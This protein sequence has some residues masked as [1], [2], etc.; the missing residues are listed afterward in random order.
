MR[1]NRLEIDAFQAIGH[2]DID[3]DNQGLVLI[4]G[5]NHDDDSA[6]SNGA[7]K[8]SIVSALQWCL[9]NITDRGDSGDAIV[10]RT[11]GKDTRVLTQIV[12][13]DRCYNVIR[14][15]KHRDH[16]NRVLLLDVTDRDNIIDL[17][18][19][20][21][22]ATQAHIN[23]IIGCSP[24]V[25]NSA[26]V[27]GQE[28]QV[29]LPNLS[30]KQLKLIVE[31]A[32]GIDKLQQA[33]VLARKAY[34][35]RKTEQEAALRQR[36]LTLATEAAITAELTGLEAKQ[37][38]HGD[39]HAEAVAAK[40][41]ELL[42]V[43]AGAKKQAEQLKSWDI[44]SLSEEQEAIATRLASID[45]E[46][47]Q[48][49][50][51]ESEQTRLGHELRHAEDRLKSDKALAATQKLQLDNVTSEIGTD[52][53]SCGQTITEAA[54]AGRQSA[55]AA[56][57]RDTVG[58]CKH[59]AAAI[60]ELRG[61]LSDAVSA[62]ET[63]TASMTDTSELVTRQQ[64]I[65]RELDA[66]AAC[67]AD[68]NMQTATAKRLRDELDKLE[69]STSP[70]LSLI[71][72]ANTRL[73][74][75]RTR[76][77][78]DN[79]A[80]EQAKAR[81]QT[82]GLVVEVFGP[83]GIRAYILDT[84]TPFLNDRTAR[85]LSVLSDNNISAVWSTLTKTAK[86]ELREKFAIEV[87]TRT[88]GE[89]FRSL[90]GGEKRKVRLSAALALQDLVSSRSAKPIQL[91]I[92]DEID[93]AVDVSGLERLMTV[94]EE[95]AKEKGTV[96]I[97]SHNSIGDWVRQHATVTKTDGVAT[98]TGALNLDLKDVTI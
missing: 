25:F 69:A 53:T 8:S 30:D 38:E 85:Y 31:E 18:Q 17:T 2:A 10:N 75:A 45:S 91:W 89:S 83:A 15:R 11:L 47:A 55:L 58:G 24:E 42:G 43:I 19:G 21:D 51:L 3:V 50:A 20:T 14:H 29:D 71:D 59:S 5:V 68:V 49:R 67:A 12:D 76:L 35:E 98:M 56:Q 82:A 61:K 36:E 33:Y 66:Q 13:G 40:R 6:N 39:Q 48:Q 80:L 95:K 32:A 94:L 84:V 4:E 77:V 52:C 93:D 92:G 72:D 78:D 16:K 60:G 86:G 9:F 57:I 27:C 97:I 28:A 23:A 44:D 46:R 74:Q 1:F 81:L 34:G 65:Q 90:S 41:A 73:D 88:A 26:I 87:T 54:V 37:A 64:A 7:G 70:Y 62:L 63:F 96:L 79:A 22:K